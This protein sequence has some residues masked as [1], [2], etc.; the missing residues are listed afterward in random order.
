[1]G[2]TSEVP[3]VPPCKMCGSVHHLSAR[4]CMA[5]YVSGGCKHCCV[6][7]D[8]GPSHTYRSCDR[9]ARVMPL[10]IWALRTD[11]GYS[12]VQ[13]IYASVRDQI[14]G[15][16]LD[17]PPKCLLSD[18]RFSPSTWG[19]HLQHI[20]GCARTN[21]CFFYSVKHALEEVVSEGRLR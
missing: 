17:L 11:D 12:R 18:N 13:R 21:A 4:P 14:F 9:S 2:L 3:P 1:M 19:L 8:N 6:H 16:V 7:N 15:P 10:V 5:R 20:C